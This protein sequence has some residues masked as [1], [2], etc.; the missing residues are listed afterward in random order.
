MALLISAIALTCYAIA[1]HFIIKK[2]PTAKSI[3]TKYLLSE[4][5]VYKMPDTKLKRKRMFLTSIALIIKEGFLMT[6][7]SW[8]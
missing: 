1:V 6:G 3:Q 7:V 4:N 8:L 5:S 2:R